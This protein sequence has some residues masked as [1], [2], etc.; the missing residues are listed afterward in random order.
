MQI[1]REILNKSY[2]EGVP[3]EKKFQLLL[4]DSFNQVKYGKKLSHISGLL[5]YL[6]NSSQ[7]NIAMQIFFLLLFS[8]SVVSDSMTPWTAAS[9]ASWSSTISWS[10]LKFMSIELVMLSNHLRLC[11]SLLLLP[12]I[13]PSIKVFSNEST[14][15][16]M[17][18]K[19]YRF[20]IS[21]SNIPIF[22]VDFLQD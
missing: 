5:G 1:L 22:R 4:M 17:W 20:S 18:P 12:S 2:S 10:L 13:F 6:N 7:F 16:I 8:H 19:Y 14:L 21:L 15:H 3:L 11:C 9:Q